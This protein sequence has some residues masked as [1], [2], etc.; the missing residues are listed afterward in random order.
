MLM[1]AGGG[2]GI[3]AIFRAPLGGALFA[4]E[5]LYSSTALEFAAV[6]P[7]FLA[8]ITAYA[9]FA[10]IFGHG[11]AFHTPAEFDFQQRQ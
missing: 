7:C 2:G 11:L 3:G 8:S 5:V 6:I 10:A 4:S 1:L 9:V